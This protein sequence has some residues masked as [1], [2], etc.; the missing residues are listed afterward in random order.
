MSATS[1]SS[2]SRWNYVI[3]DYVTDPERGQS[4]PAGVAIADPGTGRVML[5]FPAPS[6]KVRGIAGPQARMLMGTT[7]EQIEEWAATGNIPYGDASM[8]PGSSAWWELVRDLLSFSVRARPP[9]AID[10]TAPE[11]DLESLY[12]AVVGPSFPASEARQRID[13]RLRRALGDE[14]GRRLR[15]AVQIPGYEQKAVQVRCAACSPSGWVVVDAVNLSNSSQAEASADAL[16][17]KLMRLQRGQAV[18][19]LFVGYLASPGGLNGETY[20]KRWIEEQTGARAFDTTTEAEAFRRAVARS[21]D[22][23]LGQQTLPL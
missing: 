7:R 11:E 8:V 10:C 16:A 4:L 21:L 18:A 19:A 20:L 2:D 6:E 3:F 17:S 14:L 23:A 15:P 13:S 1:P 12:E 9:L 22:D 5:R